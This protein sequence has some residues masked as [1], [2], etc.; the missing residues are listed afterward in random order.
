MKLISEVD[1]KVSVKGQITI[2]KTVRQLLHANE[3]SVLTFLVYDNG[4][5]GVEKNSDY[6][7][8]EEEIKNQVMEYAAEYG[9]ADLEP[10]DWELDE[11][12]GDV[13]E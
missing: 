3:N 11:F 5:V 9:V 1:A 4:T 12:L 13:E 10:E 8:T 7:V 6:D 2:P